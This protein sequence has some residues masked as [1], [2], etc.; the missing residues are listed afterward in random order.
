MIEDKSPSKT[1]L[2]E[3]GRVWIDP[4]LDRSILKITH[5]STRSWCR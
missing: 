1:S 2:A 3:L 4:S 5:A